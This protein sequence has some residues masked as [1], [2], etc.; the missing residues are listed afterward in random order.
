MDVGIPEPVAAGGAGAAEE[1]EPWLASPSYMTGPSSPN[2]LKSKS[3]IWIMV[4]RLKPGHAMTQKGYI[5]ICTEPG[6]ANPFITLTKPKGRNFWTST[7]AG[8]NLKRYHPKSSGKEAAKAAEGAEVC[9]LCVYFFSSALM[10]LIN[11]R[12]C[13]N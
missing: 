1:A 6:Y 2:K 8:E 12:G 7:K 9:C 11:S 10:P 5:H 13:L 4:R 3:A